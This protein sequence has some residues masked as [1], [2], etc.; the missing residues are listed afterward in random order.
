M[1]S[2][3]KSGTKVYYL[4]SILGIVALLSA[5]A[6]LAGGSVPAT[7]WGYLLLSIDVLLP[8]SVAAL[9]AKRSLKKDSLKMLEA[10][11]ELCDP[12]SFIELSEHAATRIRVPFGEWGA[13][14][15]S[16]RSLA[17]NDLSDVEESR[18]A[19]EYVLL[20]IESETHR[21]KKANM[22]LSA[23]PPVARI[24]GRGEARRLVERA[25]AVYLSDPERFGDELGYIELQERALAMEDEGDSK[26]LIEILEETRG[27]RKA[28]MRVKVEAA[29]RESEALRDRND[30]EGE[31]RC[32]EFVAEN[33]GG[34]RIAREA[35]LALRGGPRT[36]GS[37]H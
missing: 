17:F 7:W 5:T 8:V 26:G 27:D 19:L 29:F 20:S 15:L 12:E 24:M 11:D 21:V 22:M 31:A 16:Y 30:I 25:K 34:L 1:K 35:R 28:S 3:C 9:L 6:W 4:V 37:L 23:Y 18:K 14:L 32:L 13:W 10:Y 36:D 2:I 33:G